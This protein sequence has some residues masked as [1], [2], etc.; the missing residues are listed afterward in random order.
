MR[1]VTDFL[2]I[3]TWSRNKKL[4][5]FAKGELEHKNWTKKD[6]GTWVR[7]GLSDVLTTPHCL[8][9]EFSKDDL[10][11]FDRPNKK[12]NVM[13][14]NISNIKLNQVKMPIHVIGRCTRL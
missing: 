14:Q 9:S 6:C 8:V 4:L 1:F 5:M 2:I 10:P 7:P 13:S 11:T 12:L 3:A